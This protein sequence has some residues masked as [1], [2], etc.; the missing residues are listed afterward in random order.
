[1]DCFAPLAMTEMSEIGWQNPSGCPRLRGMKTNAK[2]A[3]RPVPPSGIATRVDA[4]DWAQ[5]ETDLDAQGCAVL[6]GLL[7]PEECRAVAALYPDDAHF[8][9]ASSWGATALAAASTNTSPTR[10]PT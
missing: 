3:I 1:M 10:C 2:T 7:T 6:K 5:A 4:L 8:L 9:A